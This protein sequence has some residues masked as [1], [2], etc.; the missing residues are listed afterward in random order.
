MRDA[1]PNNFAPLD[2]CSVSLRTETI[3]V[4]SLQGDSFPR[5]TSLPVVDY[6]LQGP[7]VCPSNVL[8]SE[9]P[10]HTVTC[11]PLWSSPTTYSLLSD[12]SCTIGHWSR[13]SWVSWMCL[14]L[15]GIGPDLL[16]RYDW[17][18]LPWIT[19]VCLI[20]RE[21]GLDLLTRCG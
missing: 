14:I 17:N 1:S 6:D 21:V 7:T 13:L 5:P 15:R 19:W 16:T 11:I 9:S 2:Y 12:C 18:R 4:V 10:N 3:V 8:F 20:L